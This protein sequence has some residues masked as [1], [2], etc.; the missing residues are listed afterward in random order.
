MEAI[1]D[2]LKWSPPVLLVLALNILGMGLKNL[3]PISNKF[4]PLLLPLVGAVVYTG[5]GEAVPLPYIAK[6]SHPWIVYSIIGF[7]AGG[8]AVWGHQLI[9]NLKGTTAA[10]SEAEP[11]ESKA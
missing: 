6:L 4:I 3:T 11:P 9:V 10:P 5:L 1:T 7:I 2:V 8:V